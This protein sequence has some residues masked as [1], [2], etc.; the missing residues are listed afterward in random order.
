MQH[1]NRRVSAAYTTVRV[2]GGRGASGRHFIRFVNLVG[3][4]D[5]FNTKGIPSSGKVG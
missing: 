5:I 1:C 2:G 3:I 4:G